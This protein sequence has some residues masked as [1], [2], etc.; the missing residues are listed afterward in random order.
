MSSA[1]GCSEVCDD[2]FIAVAAARSPIADLRGHDLASL[3]RNNPQFSEEFFQGWF[4]IRNTTALKNKDDADGVLACAPL[5]NI[6]APSDWF[7]TA[8]R[9]LG[10]D[11]AS[12]VP[13]LTKAISLS[14]PPDTVT[15][16]GWFDPVERQRLAL[17]VLTSIG[18]AIASTSKEEPKLLQDRWTPKRTEGDDFDESV[19]DADEDDMMKDFDM[20]TGTRIIDFTDRDNAAVRALASRSLSPVLVTDMD[21]MASITHITGIARALARVFS[22]K[23]PLEV[24]EPAK[25]MALYRASRDGTS[26][27]RDPF[28]T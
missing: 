5:H 8:V 25:L 1:S 7:L 27:N 23:T 14:T 19:T 28:R 20:V 17:E 6:Y 3:I 26:P 11:N 12:L 13:T 24:G 16:G 10:A 9:H 21:D 15:G 4:R 2:S 22:I 18:T